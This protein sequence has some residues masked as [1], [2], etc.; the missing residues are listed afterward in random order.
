MKITAIKQQVAR[1]SR[2]SIFVDDKYS[3]SL[4]DSALLDTGIFSGKLI[5]DAELQQL[6]QFSVADKSYGNA[7]RYA[8][9]RPRSEWEMSQ[10]LIRKKVE[11]DDQAK[12]INRLRQVG[13]LDD[14]AFAHTW[15]ANRRL[16]K[17]V[18]VRKLLL[19]LQQKHVPS[20]AIQAA[21]ADDESDD[22]QALREIIQR[23]AHRY[24]DKVK[25]IAY[26]GRQGFR[27]DDIKSVLSD[28]SDDLIGD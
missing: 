28:D 11:P 9:M 15:V 7:L 1:P 2:F 18:S 25:L 24:P 20:S 13:L 6:K 16:L 14:Q 22:K 3:F 5:D 19:E 26:L 10:Y 12:I 17:S 21:L 4:S 23:K 8:V 27:Y